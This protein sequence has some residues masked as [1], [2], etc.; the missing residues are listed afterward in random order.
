VH[1]IAGGFY[2]RPMDQIM[3]RITDFPSKSQPPEYTSFAIIRETNITHRQTHY[4]YFS[5]EAHQELVKEG[6]AVE[7]WASKDKKKGVKTGSRAEETVDIHIPEF[8]EYGFPVTISNRLLHGD[9]TATL[10]ESQKLGKVKENSASY[11]CLPGWRKG[12]RE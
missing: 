7:S 6:L 10:A 12:F 8:D 3:H 11:K 2:Y 1:R 9:G 4:H 5:Y